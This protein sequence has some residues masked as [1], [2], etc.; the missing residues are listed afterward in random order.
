MK[1]IGE[2]FQIGRFVFSATGMDVDEDSGRPTLHEWIRAGEFIRLAQGSG[3]WWGD[4]LRYGESRE[5]WR[6]R[7]SQAVGDSPY[8]EQTLQKLKYLS[9]NV[10][11]FRRRNDLPISLH[12]EVAKLDPEGQT[13]W[14]T[15]AADEHFS[16]RDLRMAIRKASRA[17]VAKGKADLAGMFRVVYADPPWQYHDSGVVTEGDAYGKVERHYQ[18]MTIEAIAT[19]PIASHAMTDAVL[20]LWCPE[21]LRFEVKPVI[22]AWG[23]AHKSA[24][25]WDKV[26]HNFGHYISVRHEHLLICTRGSCTPDRLTPMID[27]VQTFRR[28]E[29][30][31]EK[32]EDFRTLIERLYDGPYL[33]LFGRHAADNWTVTGNDLVLLDGDTRLVGNL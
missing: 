28:S 32:P 19:L 7:W 30:H 29:V 17:T 5:D 25:V 3:W 31:S 22:D 10:A 21:P 2:T 11:S 12:F 16:V 14:L 9:E 4:W 1:I 24:F 26:A 18:T 8:E 20:F 27:S 33:E 15:K 13:A 23:F 6:E